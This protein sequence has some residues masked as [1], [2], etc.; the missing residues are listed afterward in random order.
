MLCLLFPARGFKKPIERVVVSSDSADEFETWPYT[1]ITPQLTRE[2]QRNLEERSRTT[3]AAG[4][5]T[6]G[7]TGLLGKD[8]L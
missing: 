7:P 5:K 8:V 3:S 6:R 1:E 4:P 2:P